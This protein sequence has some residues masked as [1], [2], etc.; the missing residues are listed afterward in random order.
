MSIQAR[1]LRDGTIEIKTDEGDRLILTT[2]EARTFHTEIEYNL[3]S[4]YPE[5]PVDLD[6]CHRIVVNDISLTIQD[7]E[8][9]ASRLV[10]LIYSLEAKLTDLEK[11]NWLI[12]GF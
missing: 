5:A 12:E 4:I 2:D 10:F 1:F 11:V 7:A 8:Q 6:Y 9:L 3:L